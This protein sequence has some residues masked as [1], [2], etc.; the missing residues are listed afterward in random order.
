MA[1]GKKEW[2]LIARS[3]N[4]QANDGWNVHSAVVNWEDSELFC[5]HCNGKI[6][7]AYGE[8]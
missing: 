1:C 6:E 8:N 4:T 2:R 5:D 3:I 7:S